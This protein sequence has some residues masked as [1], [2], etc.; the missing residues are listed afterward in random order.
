MSEIIIECMRRL[1]QSL[2]YV[3]QI[4]DQRRLFI[5]GIIAVYAEGQGRKPC[6]G[7][8]FDEG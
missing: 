7:G 3:E 5:T 6:G 2:G 8:Q 4:F 1:D